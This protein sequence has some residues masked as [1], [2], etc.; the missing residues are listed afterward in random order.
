[1]IRCGLVCLMAGALAW[2]Q[3][4]NTKSAPAAQKPAAQST[5]PST[6][7]QAPAAESE[8]SKVA[9]DTPVIT[10]KGVCDPETAK[11]PS[12]ECRTQITRAEFEKIMDSVQPNMPARVR[13]QF[14]M[15]YATMLTMS[16]KAAAMGLDKGPD[17]DERMKLARMQVLATEL[18]K[19]MQ[20]KASEI[21]DKEVDDYYKNN[22]DHFQ[23]AEMLRIYVPKEKQEA[24]ADK[25]KKP[26]EEEQ[27]KRS[28]EAAKEM[29][30]VADKLQPRAA[31][32]EDF[33]KLQEEA[34]QAAG[35]KSAAPNT[36]MGKVR[37]NV[38]PPT[39]TSVMDLKPG[40]VSPVIE[41]QGG[42]F[43]YKM[44]SKETMPLD[45]AKDE[46]RGTLRSQ[47]LQDSMRTLQESST[48]TLDEA[49]FGPETPGRG[50]MSPGGPGAP[51][52]PGRPGTPPGPK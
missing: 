36:N 34:Y 14:A 6:G 51:P 26:T 3:A 23:E 35:I 5:S 38:L 8:A 48:P 22:L 44:V 31:K 28:E 11:S 24:E 41:D 32:G 42:F 39:Q 15:R 27:Q 4:A 13:R 37:R 50:P 21:T 16:Q 10:I 47:R 43:I 7:T 9:P 33:N 18:N 49:Y 46:I 1:M 45:Q 25:D 12:L 29:K 40:E 20:Q 52:A 17:F 19:D 30:A 2:G